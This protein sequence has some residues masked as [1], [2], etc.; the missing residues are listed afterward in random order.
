MDTDTAGPGAQDIKAFIQTA[1][2]TWT[3]PPQYLLLVGDTNFI[4]AWAGQGQGNPPTDLAY[5]EMNGDCLPDLLCGRL[6]VTRRCRS[7]CPPAAA[8][9]KSAP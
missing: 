7:T 3:L 4:P 6:P 9:P 5:S 8:L 2:F 1:Y